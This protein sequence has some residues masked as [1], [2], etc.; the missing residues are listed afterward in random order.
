MHTPN[1]TSYHSLL[2]LN[3]FSC[4][5]LYINVFHHHNCLISIS[6]HNMLKQS[7]S[8]FTYFTLY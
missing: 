4:T 8:T 2:Y 1:Q 7:E 5:F 6:Y 3:I